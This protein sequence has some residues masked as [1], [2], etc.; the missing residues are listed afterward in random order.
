MWNSKRSI[1]LSLLCL[2]LFSAVFTAVEIFAV[3]LTREFLSLFGKNPALLPVLAGWIY[4]CLLPVG[5]ALFLLH[6]I[7][8]WVRTERIFCNENVRRLRH[9]SWC[10]FAVAIISL[11]F[12]FGY[13][14]L[15]LI[16][17]IA[18][19]VGLILRVVKNG[20]QRALELEE[21]SRMTI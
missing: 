16:A 9:L 3:P 10:C 15:F 8:L 1:T 11:G 21:D 12:G 6:Q 14:P 5:Y 2:Y 17:P 20:C 7:L 19:F 18:A 4:A 13:F